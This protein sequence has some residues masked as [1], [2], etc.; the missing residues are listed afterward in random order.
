MMKIT[1][2]RYTVS[3]DRQT[4]Y[5]KPK[6]ESGD[7]CVPNRPQYVRMHHPATAEFK[8]FTLTCAWIFPPDGKFSARLNERKI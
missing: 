5:T 4:L 1:Y 3:Y 6:S 2:V 8:P 7:I